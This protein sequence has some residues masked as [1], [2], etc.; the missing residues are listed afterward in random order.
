MGNCCSNEDG[1]GGSAHIQG[2]ANKPIAM[3]E[4]LRDFSIAINY[5]PLRRDEDSIPNTVTFGPPVI[6]HEGE[7]ILAS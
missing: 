1:G 4:S 6:L 7:D 3:D 2:I 5:G